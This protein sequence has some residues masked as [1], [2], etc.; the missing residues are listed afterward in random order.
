MM[1]RSIASGN[2]AVFKRGGSEVLLW[3]RDPEI[4]ILCAR[5][6]PDGKGQ[7]G[8]WLPAKRSQTADIRDEMDGFVR[9]KG[10]IAELN[11]YRKPKLIEHVE[12]DL[13]ERDGE[14]A[15]DVEDV[16]AGLGRLFEDEADGLRDVLDGA[17][18]TQLR[19]G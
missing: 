5:E 1:L 15:A 17:E 3:S 11:F 16:S 9:V 4:R 19:A 6:L 2:E 13:L 14:T 10:E 18:I 12:H 7:V 8:A